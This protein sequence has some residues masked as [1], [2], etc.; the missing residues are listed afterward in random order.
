MSQPPVRRG[1]PGYDLDTLLSVAV[2]VF[3]ERGYEGTSMED[4]A[5]R[6]GIT[7]SAIYHHVSINEELLRRSVDFDEYAEAPVVGL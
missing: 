2:L 1:R 3:N 5:G 4:L 6:L 7:K